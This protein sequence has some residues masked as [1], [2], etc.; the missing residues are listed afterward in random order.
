[1]SPRSLQVLPTPYTLNPTP[2]T[3][4]PAPSTP[5]P[6]PHT[7]HPTLHTLSQVI[8]KWMEA[9]LDVSSFPLD[10]VLRVYGVAWSVQGVGCRV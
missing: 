1:M 8:P 5:H 4:H 6:T 7:L 3:L 2:C 10:S 9:P